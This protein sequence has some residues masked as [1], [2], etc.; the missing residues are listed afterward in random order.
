MPFIIIANTFGSCGFK[1]N[2][3][4]GQSTG[5]GD[6]GGGVSAN[7]AAIR[8]D[9]PSR[10]TQVDIAATFQQRFGQENEGRKA[11]KGHGR[12]EMPRS[13]GDRQNK[14]QY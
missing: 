8:L 1:L 10:D 4:G 12:A 5:R 13:A 11:L 6:S 9:L 2:S 3:R 14:P 7:E